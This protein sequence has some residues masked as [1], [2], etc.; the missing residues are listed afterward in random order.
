[1]T[2]WGF[3]CSY[4]FQKDEWEKPSVCKHI[5][6]LRLVDKNL[7]WERGGT[8]AVYMLFSIRYFIWLN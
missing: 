1:M 5:V 3:D 8:F 2:P 7:A 6:Q 4:V